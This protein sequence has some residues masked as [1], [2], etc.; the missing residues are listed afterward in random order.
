MLRKFSA[1]F[2][3]AMSLGAFAQTINMVPYQSTIVKVSKDTITN[4]AANVDYQTLEGKSAVVMTSKE[5]GKLI[6]VT[7]EDLNMDYGQSISFYKGGKLIDAKKMLEVESLYGTK[8]Y[9]YGDTITVALDNE[10]VLRSKFT[11]ITETITLAPAVDFKVKPLFPKP[12]QS[13][14]ENNISYSVSLVPST[15]LKVSPL[16]TQY[17]LSKDSVFSK[18]DIFIHEYYTYGYDQYSTSINDLCTIDPA[19]PTGKYYLLLVLD[20][21][22]LVAETNEKNNVVVIPTTV[23]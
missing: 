13:G 5:K 12:L 10:T 16:C 14:S 19:I 22:R 21:K 4:N 1:V 6:K 23:E 7:L 2:L 8:A 11:L 17:Y 15:N 3:S 18:D 20:P 9:L